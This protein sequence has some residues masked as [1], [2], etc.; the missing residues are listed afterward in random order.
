MNP[1]E[2]S[3]LSVE[4]KAATSIA[5]KFVPARLRRKTFRKGTWRGDA[6]VFGFQVASIVLCIGSSPINSSR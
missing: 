6:I 2:W 5:T 4:A 1:L 3:H